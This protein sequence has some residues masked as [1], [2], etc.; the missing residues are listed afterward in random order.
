MALTGSDESGAAAT[1]VLVAERSAALRTQIAALVRGFDPAATVV[2]ASTG[3][4][5]FEACLRQRPDIAF[6]GL[7]FEDLS[8]PE[9][10]ATLKAKGVALPCLILLASQVFPRW[11]EVSQHLDA[12]EFLRTPLDVEHVTGLLH[13][14]VR[15]HR[16]T[17]LL[18]VD[19][20]AQSRALVRRILGRSGFRLEV[21]ETDNGQH[22]VKLIRLGTCDVAMIDLG[23][24]GMDGLEL[25]CHA[26]DVAPGTPLI[27]MTGGNKAVLAQAS[28]HFGV[29]YVLK[30]PFFARDVDRVMYHLLSLRRPYLLNAITEG[31]DLPAGNRGAAR[32]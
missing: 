6:V 16:P 21:E 29:D 25:A 11:T 28:R 27:L 18:L 13:A 17:R 32:A 9:A 19:S 14:Y 10:V 7:Q 12:Y 1:V 23:L 5:T 8:G 3:R 2:E 31:P 20:A 24:K 26:R 30:K 22:A 4:A 15:R